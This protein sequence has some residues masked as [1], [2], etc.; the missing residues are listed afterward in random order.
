MGLP[1]A[2]IAQGWIP[3]VVVLLLTLVFS[4]LYINYFKSK[5]DS[6][7]ATTSTAVLALTIALLTTFLVPVDVFLVSFMKNSNGTFQEWAED[8]QVRQSIEDTVLYAYYALY[9]IMAL[10]IF[11]I[12]PFV[13]F[14]YEERDEI[15]TAATKICGALKFTL[16]FLLVAAVLIIMGS[17]IPLKEAPPTNSSVWEEINFLVNELG[18]NKGEDVLSFVLSVLTVIGM[19]VFIIFGGYGMSALPCGMI[20]GSRSVTYDREEMR[21]Q[22]AVLTRRAD[23]IREKYSGDRRMSSRDQSRVFELEEQLR[24]LDRQERHLD[25]ASQSWW[26]KCLT[27]LRPFEMFAGVALTVI[28]LLVFVSLMITNIDKAINSLGPQMGYALPM[29]KL[30]NPI[31]IVLVYAE[32][33]FPLDYILFTGIVF[34]CLF[35]AMSAL[36]K[37]GI[38][39]LWIRMYRIRPRRTRPQG[40]LMMCMTLMFIILAINVILYSVTPQYVMY[41]SQQYWGNKTENSDVESVMSQ[42][43]PCSTHAPTDECTMSRTSMLLTRF[44]Y[45]A[46]IFGAIYYWGSWAFL[47]V[48]LIGSIWS[49]F[50]RRSSSIEGR[51]DSDD[52]D[53]SDDELLHI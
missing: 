39:F 17:L 28:G 49:I 38:W 40:L 26:R 19:F 14:Y 50:K 51:V 44:C 42:L 4:W 30:P 21:D 31:D 15:A 5:Y 20:K 45:K 34:F 13:Y 7:I 12:L 8:A 1:S 23:G 9:G 36:R 32:V 2:V 33:V 18:S 25:E 47:A 27:V 10:C 53:E 37:M 43:M 22:R 11:V 16:V 29:R 41:G 3:F 35:C 24:L 46:W 52:F 6:D 48:V